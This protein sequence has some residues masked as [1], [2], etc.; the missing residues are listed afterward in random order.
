MGLASAVPHT[1]NATDPRDKIY[2]ALG[3][4]TDSSLTPVA[5]YSLPT[6]NVYLQFA[7]YMITHGHGIEMLQ[8]AAA[9]PSTLDFPSWV[10]DWSSS[11]AN[12]SPTF[13][14]KTSG[15]DNIQAAGTSEQYVGLGKDDRRIVVY[16][17][18]IDT[19]I[20]L[21]PPLSTINH[22]KL[23]HEDGWPGLQQQRIYFE[24]AG[25]PTISL[26]RVMM[27]NKLPVPKETAG[28]L[29][30]YR[31]WLRWYTAIPWIGDLGVKVL[32]EHQNLACFQHTII[33]W[34]L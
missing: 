2:A 18:H 1:L 16:G 6:A 15:L 10:P 26:A 21:G 32:A 11:V 27:D 22:E 29:S 14:H 8:E 3:L 7:K 17:R 5:D 24:R 20:A 34:E 13:L 23:K 12:I 30:S 19:I 9:F 28:M 31:E 25:Q 33:T 4:A